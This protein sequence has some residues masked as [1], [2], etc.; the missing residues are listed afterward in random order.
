MLTTGA[1]TLTIVL[2]GWVIGRLIRN[3]IVIKRH[4]RFIQEWN[5]TVAEYDFRKAEADRKTRELELEIQR[6]LS[7]KDNG[8]N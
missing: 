1:I 4:E 5:A 7:K 2:C 6:I 8:G 3:L